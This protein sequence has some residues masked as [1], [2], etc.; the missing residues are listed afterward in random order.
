M[1]AC[2]HMKFLTFWKAHLES[3]LLVLDSGLKLD[4]AASP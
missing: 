1:T 2:G 3:A 4:L